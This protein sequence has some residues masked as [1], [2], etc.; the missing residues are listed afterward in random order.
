[1]SIIMQFAA[2]LGFLKKV[3]QIHLLGN[4]FFKMALKTVIVDI[5]KILCQYFFRVFWNYLFQ[6][7]KW[8]M[9]A[10][11]VNMGP[12]DFTGGSWRGAGYK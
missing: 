11:N 10:S 9:T 7:S 8:V 5:T 3:E 6:V 4:E 1:M 2:P 12:S